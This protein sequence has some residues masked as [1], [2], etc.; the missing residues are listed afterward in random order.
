MITSH[1]RW[2]SIK[3]IVII[4][5]FD[6]G[7]SCC[8]GWT[9]FGTSCYYVSKNQKTWED[10]RGE[11]QRKGADLVII[12]NEEENVSLLKLSLANLIRH[13]AVQ[14]LYYHLSYIC[15]FIS[16]RNLLFS[17]K[18][19]FGSGW[20]TKMRRASGNGWMGQ[21]WPQGINNNNIIIVLDLLMLK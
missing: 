21:I 14:L 15:I 3:C 12:N 18:K 5:I 2:I 20:L 19:E 6:T 7:R 16:N 8:E 13:P 4:Y 1:R 11:C 9:K 10:S 17:S